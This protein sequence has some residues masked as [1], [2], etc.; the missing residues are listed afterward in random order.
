M[1]LRDRLLPN[2]LIFKKKERTSFFR[3]K[4]NEGAF[5]QYCAALNTLL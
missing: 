3:N 1:K 5:S 2:K 4:E